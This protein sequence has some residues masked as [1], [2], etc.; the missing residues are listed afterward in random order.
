[1][2]PFQ[3]IV[4]AFDGS[5]Q[6]IHATNVV[7]E[8]AL[9][10]HSRVTLITVVPPPGPVYSGLETP[11]TVE[12]VALPFREAAQRQKARLEKAG[13]I[14][15]AVEVRAGSP[16]REILHFMEERPFDL[17]VMGARGLSDLGRVFL[18]SVSDVVVH[19]AHCPILVVRPPPSS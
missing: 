16:A 7:L 11:P 1:M 10:F 8:L 17:L 13:L 4:V 2:S 14:S 5:E 19:H 18:G 6:S 3:S 15:V 12:E 9:R